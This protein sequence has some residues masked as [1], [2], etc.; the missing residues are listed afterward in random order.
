MSIAP[1]PSRSSARARRAGRPSS[2]PRCPWRAR[3]RPSA[4]R[5][6]ASG[7]RASRGR[8]RRRREQPAARSRTPDRAELDHVPRALAHRDL[9]RRGHWRLLADAADELD[10][11]A[12]KV[13]RG[14]LVERASG[15]RAA[16]GRAL[17]L[18]DA[19]PTTARRTD[20]T[21]G[22]RR[23]RI[24]HAHGA[25]RTVAES[26]SCSACSPRP[27]PPRTASSSSA[28]S[29][30]PRSPRS[31]GRRSSSTARRRSRAGARLPRRC[32]G[33]AR[34][35]RRRR[36]SRTSPFCACSREG[37]GA[38][39]STLGEL[40][41]AQAAG[42]PGERL[43]V[44]GNNKIDEELRAAAE[45]GRRPR[46]ARL[47]GGGRACCGRRRR[48]RARPRHLGHRGRHPRVDPHRVPRLEVRPPAADRARSHRRARAAD[49]TCKASTS[50]SARSCSTR[51]PRG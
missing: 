25:A 46:R 14:R 21:L 33:R 16:A 23:P 20:E 50:T 1:P 36:R 10:R 7:R 51:P 13:L 40:R 42:L 6:S 47:A 24:A 38:D 48:P 15:A 28:V 19:P 32:S 41:F 12:Q 8:R 49:S 26:A 45:A 11:D 30:P 9:R 37:L 18:V 44:H 17:R 34:L 31:S 2:P 43:V 35:L 3:R 27:R 5:S 29:A 39:V 4:R 22:Q